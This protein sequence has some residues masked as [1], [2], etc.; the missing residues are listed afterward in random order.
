M[1][2]IFKSRA[3]LTEQEKITVKSKEPTDVQEFNIES[4]IEYT[5]LQT[6]AEKF[7]QRTGKNF[8]ETI[9]PPIKNE[10]SNLL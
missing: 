1:R 6:Y 9:T 4:S 10:E 8:W 3:W 2:R 7:K 5:D